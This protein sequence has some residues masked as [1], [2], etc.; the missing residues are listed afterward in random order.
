MTTID[1]SKLAAVA[2]AFHAAH[3]DTRLIFGKSKSPNAFALWVDVVFANGWNL[4]VEMPTTWFSDH[5]I[6]YIV[7]QIEQKPGLKPPLK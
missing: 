2:E 3:P 1:P 4:I 5:D 7:A 6:P